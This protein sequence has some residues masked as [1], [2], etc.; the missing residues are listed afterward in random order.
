MEWIEWNTWWF[1]DQDFI[2]SFK[3][4]VFFMDTNLS[5]LWLPRH[6]GTSTSVCHLL[7]HSEG[8]QRILQEQLGN[9]MLSPLRP[10]WSQW[11][12]LNNVKTWETESY[13][14]KLDFAHRMCINL[15]PLKLLSW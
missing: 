4:S 2:L 13:T 3:L 14:D 9:S 8:E 15:G 1:K 11:K 5:C 12:R 10:M 6:D 7:Y